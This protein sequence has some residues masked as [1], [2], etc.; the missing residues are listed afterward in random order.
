M[1]KQ[2][3]AQPNPPPDASHLP[4]SLRELRVE[5]DIA[6]ALTDDELRAVQKFRRAAD[7]IAAGARLC[8]P[9]SRFLV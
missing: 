6:D 4:D 2:E 9:S 1:P 7:Y 3:I 5:L 8:C